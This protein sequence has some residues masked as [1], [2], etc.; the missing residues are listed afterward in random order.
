VGDAVVE[1]SK[2]DVVSVDRASDGEYV[3]CILEPELH[4]TVS[5]VINKIYKPSE[6]NFFMTP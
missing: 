5:R 3:D 1:G 6:I 4:W 2:V